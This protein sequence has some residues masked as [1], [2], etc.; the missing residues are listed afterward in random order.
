MQFVPLHATDYRVL[1]ATLICTNFLY[2]PP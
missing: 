2:S 1:D